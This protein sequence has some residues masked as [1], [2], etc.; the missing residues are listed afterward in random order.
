MKTMTKLKTRTDELG[1][2]FALIKDLIPSEIN[3]KIYGN[4][5]KESSHSDEIAEDMT[6]RISK[7]LIANTVPIPVYPSGKMKGGHNRRKGALKAGAEEVQVNILSADEEEEVSNNSYLETMSMVSDNTLSKDKDHEVI[8]EEYNAIEMSY[9]E[10]HGQLAPDPDKKLWIKTINAGASFVQVTQNL[11]ENLKVIKSRDP[12]LFDDLRKGMKVSKAFNIVKNTKP[13][14]KP[15][16]NRKIIPIFQDS[17]NVRKWLNLFKQ[18]IENFKKENTF[19]HEDGEV[20]NWVMDDYVG[21]ESNFISNAYSQ[22]LQGTVT[23]FFRKYYPKWD[24]KSP[25][26]EI[27]APDTQFHAF[28]KVGMDPLRLESKVFDINA[29]VP[30]VYFGLGGA[31]GLN[32][33]EFII[34]A[35]QGFDR[36]CIFIT[37]LTNDGPRDI[38]GQGSG[39]IM[40]IETWFKNHFEKKDWHCLHGDIKKDQNG[41]MMMSCEEL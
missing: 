11:I 12:S 9:Q 15:R 13:K 1:N 23:S 10:V 29:K 33:H 5:S 3:K 21:P 22:I 32:P 39:S 16:K 36:F 24:A 30:T 17:E 6:I 8:L 7:G 18:G 40:T 2:T 26:S 35:R 4:E 28:N 41:K 38:K 19:K 31:M 20:V 25:R 37:T 34:I 14:S 27:G